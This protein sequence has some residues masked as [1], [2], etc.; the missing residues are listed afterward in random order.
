MIGAGP[1]LDL[2]LTIAGIIAMGIIVWLCCT[3][4]K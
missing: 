4:D 1:A 2:A 3:K